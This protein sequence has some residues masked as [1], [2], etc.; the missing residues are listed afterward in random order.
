[1]S[2]QRPSVRQQLLAQLESGSKDLLALHLRTRLDEGVIALGLT[3]LER[4]GRV[5][6]IGSL[7]QLVRRA[8][9]PA[10]RVSLAPAVRCA[11]A[12]CAWT[13]GL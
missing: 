9:K 6:R 10:P 5:R 4:T 12:R 2:V 11:Q 3:S 13:V 7:W 1:M 8:E